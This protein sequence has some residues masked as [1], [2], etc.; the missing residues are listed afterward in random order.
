MMLLLLRWTAYASLAAV[1]RGRRTPLPRSLS[2]L[3]AR[4]VRP[5][6]CPRD[7]ARMVRRDEIIPFSLE[8]ALDAREMPMHRRAGGGAIPCCQCGHA[9][10]VIGQRLVAQRTRV[11]MLLDLRP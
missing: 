11:E 5:R 6:C 3:G 1:S 7:C 2:I 8:F 10:F 9:G 4:A